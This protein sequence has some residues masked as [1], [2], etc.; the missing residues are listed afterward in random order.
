MGVLF[1]LCVAPSAQAGLGEPAASVQRDHTALRGTA[2][3]VTPT[4]AYS[5][6]EISTPGGRV[7]EYVSSA[8]RVFAVTWSGRSNPD[9]SLLLGTHYAEYARTAKIHRGN[10]KV[11]SLVTAGLVMHVTKLPRGFVGEA[12]AP[13][14][15]PSG[16]SAGDIR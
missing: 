11:F 8:D 3:T 5:L 15:L 12:H 4:P 10:H 2:L 6:H 9:L 14:L 1:G 16:V 13:A 7:R